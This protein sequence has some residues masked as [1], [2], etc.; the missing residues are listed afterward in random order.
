MG[1]IMTAIV[2]FLEAEKLRYWKAAIRPYILLFVEA[3]SAYW[4]CIL[5][6]HERREQAIARVLYPVRVPRS[7]IPRVNEY[8]T[9]ATM[10]L[11]VGNFEL[12]LDDGTLGYK[13][14]I[15]VTGTELTPELVRGLIENAITAADI[16]LIGIMLVAFGSM[17]PLD[18]LDR[19]G[20]YPLAQIFDIANDLF[21]E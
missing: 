15:D 1:R 11:S 10:D 18:A 14:S 19:I 4:I 17:R 16:H 2:A 3:E 13:T 5:E 12:N 7:R 9:R 6:A 21:G 20:R 8:I